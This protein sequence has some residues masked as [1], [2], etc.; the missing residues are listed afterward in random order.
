MLGNL[1]WPETLR[2]ETEDFYFPRGKREIQDH[3]RGKSI[4]GGLVEHVNQHGPVVSVGDDQ[5]DDRNPLH[6]S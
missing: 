4:G 1:G 3:F 2:Q 6:L 5:R